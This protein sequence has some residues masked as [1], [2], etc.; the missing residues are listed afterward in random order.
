FG[1]NSRVLKWIVD[2]I[3]GEADAIETPIGHLPT[4]EAL[5]VGALGL[6][7]NAV[8]TLL[9]VDAATWTDEAARNR[10]FLEEFGA[11]IPPALMRQQQA[12]EERLASA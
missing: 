1:E 10:T 4:A 9:S 7:T 12:L 5:D 6:S 2:R 3:E 11:P 8:E